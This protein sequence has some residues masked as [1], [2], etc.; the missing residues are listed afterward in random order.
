MGSSEELHATWQML[1]V[2]ARAIGKA[3]H[4][5]L[6]EFGVS[7]DATSVMFCVTQLGKEATPSAISR[8]LIVEPH[9]VSQL[10]T[11]LERDGLVRRVKDL[12]FKNRVR[13]ELTRDGK[14]IYRKSLRRRST[15]KIMSALTADEREQIWLLL[16]KLR[17]AAL[18]QI[19][20]KPIFVYPP[21]DRSELFGDKA[22][23]VG[24][25][26]SGTKGS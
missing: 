1:S 15:K 3:R 2:T 19:G 5:E 8:Q 20:K 7:G 9:S 13:I 12:E 6:A 23:S 24:A 4:K 21:S 22:I 17:D 10:L 25:D 16:A 14:D 18:K 11:R 26:E